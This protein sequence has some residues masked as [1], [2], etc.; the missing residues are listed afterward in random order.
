MVG[1]Q[2]T[3]PE[4]MGSALR[5]A[6]CCRQ[7]SRS[8]GQ[9]GYT[10]STRGFSQVR[11]VCTG[12][13]TPG[14]VDNHLDRSTLDQVD[15]VGTSVNGPVTPA[16]RITGTGRSGRGRLASTVTLATT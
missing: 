5:D 6:A 1:L 10:G 12:S 2:R 3:D 13:A 7:G 15:P 11:A 8:G 16:Q 4:L 14:A 9:Q